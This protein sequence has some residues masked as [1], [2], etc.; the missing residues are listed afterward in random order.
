MEN[1]NQTTEQKVEVV[2]RNEFLDIIALKTKKSKPLA[3]M[4]LDAIEEAIFELLRSVDEYDGQVIKIKLFNGIV[5]TAEKI[6]TQFKV[7][8]FDDKKHLVVGYVKPK[9]NVSR[10]YVENINKGLRYK[11]YA[12]KASKGVTW[13][14]D[15]DDD[16]DITVQ[17]GKPVYNKNHYLL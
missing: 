9:V 4:F 7:N 5:F 14:L 15:E 6:P 10:R 12:E 13:E 11:S 3:K 16:L 1:E 17:T 2:S 8:N